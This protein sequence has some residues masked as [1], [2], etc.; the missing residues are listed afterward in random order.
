[1]KY[2]KV[3]S[4][5]AVLLFLF[6]AGI[7]AQTFT[8]SKKYITKEIKG[9]NSFN[10]IIV[11]GSPD[12]EY[13]QSTGSRATV[14][15]YGPDNLVDLLEISTVEG[16]L[17]VSF[18]KG[19]HIQGSNFQL[20]V[21]VSSPTLNQ[22]DIKGSS[23]VYLKGSIK[24]EN[25]NLIVTGSGD[26]K[27]EKLQIRNLSASVKGSG[28]ISLKNLKATSVDIKVNGS[29]DVDVDGSTQKAALTVSGSGDISAYGL[30][31]ANVVANIF[32]SGDIDCY[33]SK[34]L[35]AK[36]EGSGEI[37]YKGNPK[38]VNKQGRKDNISK[39]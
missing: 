24:G 8:P 21:I 4:M 27:T 1:M 15:I 19:T 2:L 33:A 5:L 3:T 12:V 16:V 32:G 29:G 13:T 28:D 10:S 18:K 39:K 26:I 17:Q 35:D 31:A 7:Q 11:V 20:K 23:D 22:V 14:S 30:N 25:M 9:I 36:V 37:D 6:I 34:Q 38:I